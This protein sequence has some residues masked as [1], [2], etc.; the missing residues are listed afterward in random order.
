MQQGVQH[1]TVYIPD[2]GEEAPALN[3]PDL[4]G[5]VRRGDRVMVNTTAVDLQL[6]SGGYHF[7]M[8]GP[9]MPGHM[10][11]GHGHIMK[12][13]YTPWQMRV[14]AVEEQDSPHHEVLSA[15]DSVEGMP[16]VCLELHSQV[17]P[18]VAGIRSHNDSFKVA[19]IMTD[20][21]ALPLQMSSTI[22]YLLKRS[23]LSTTVSAGNAFGGEREAVNI[24]SALLA[25]R[26]VENADVA[27]VSIGPGAVGTGT[28]FGHSG[29]QQAQALNASLSLDA[30]PVMSPRF[31]RGDHRKRHSGMSHHSVTILRRAIFD[32][33]YLV[34]PDDAGWDVWR[35][36]RKSRVS[37]LHRTVST[38]GWPGMQA[39][40][41]DPRAEEMGGL[42][43]Y[44]GRSHAD[45]IEYF[46]AA[47]AAGHF[48]AQM[49]GP[50]GRVDQ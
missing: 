39:I 15:S 7:V 8:W 2:R 19:Y 34:L 26:H 20:G 25:A 45:E 44:M 24:Y 5:R 4:T 49:A 37:G 31:S 28:V 38:P 21:A 36:L 50:R 12:L 40:L 23:W 29:M 47:S 43:R 41:E 32:R 13:N 27:V 42:L 30:T 48:A 16:V 18:T 11:P 35:M 46:L 17:L 10:G 9:E 22:R 33:I 6:G 14:L 3:Y 1:C